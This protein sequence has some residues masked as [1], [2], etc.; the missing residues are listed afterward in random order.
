M[1][2]W[3]NCH[4]RRDRINPIYELAKNGLD[5]VPAA[6]VVSI[7]TTWGEREDGVLRYAFYLGYR[8]AAS[9]LYSVDKAENYS[10]LMNM[11]LLAEHELGFTQNLAEQE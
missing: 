11:I 5:E 1:I 4:S 2:S 8:Y 9:I 7:E 10:K 6:H 3:K